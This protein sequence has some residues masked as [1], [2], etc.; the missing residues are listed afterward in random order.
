M[1]QNIGK[2]TLLNSLPANARLTLSHA[3]LI[4]EM[5]INLPATVL[6]KR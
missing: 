5:G 4:Y 2:M 1:P 6:K 3:N